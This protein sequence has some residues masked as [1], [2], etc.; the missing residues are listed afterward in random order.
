[1]VVMATT[2]SESQQ[3]FVPT[4]SGRNWY[5]HSD[6]NIRNNSYYSPYQYSHHGKKTKKFCF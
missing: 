4:N 5:D 2:E 3:L 1:M 6:F